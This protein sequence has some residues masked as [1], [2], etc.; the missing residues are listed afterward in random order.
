MIGRLAFAM[1]VAAPLCA[2][3][4]AHAQSGS[5]YDERIA[6]LD[7]AIERCQ[8]RIRSGEIDECDVYI[9]WQDRSV[10]LSVAQEILQSLRECA[11]CNQEYRRQIGVCD[12]F[13]PPESQVT[14]HRE[15]LAKARDAFD[16]CLAARSCN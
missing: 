4:V 8:D 16:A 3:S 7:G 9:A 2:L 14:E 12:T 10:S 1:L 13:Y 15:C 11:E 5:V 6:K